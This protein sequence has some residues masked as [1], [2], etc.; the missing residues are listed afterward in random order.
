MDRREHGATVRQWSS[1]RVQRA[2]NEQPGAPPF[3][4]GADPE[5][6]TGRVWA[7]SERRGAAANIARVYGW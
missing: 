6:V 1:A 3:S 5:M 2:A 7:G 4:I